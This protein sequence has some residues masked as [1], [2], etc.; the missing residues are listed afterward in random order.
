M[1]FINTVKGWVGGLTE[2]FLML[3]ALGIVLGLLFGANVPF[4][5]G[6]TT[7]IIAFV[8]ELGKAGLVGLLALGF[9][10]WLFSHRK[11]T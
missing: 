5:S 8:N 10:L 9:I 11:M 1:D 6:V 3:I 7:N 2:L 4:L